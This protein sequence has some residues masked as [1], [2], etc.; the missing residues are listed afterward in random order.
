M[1]TFHTQYLFEIIDKLSP[2]LEAMQKR[3]QKT[4]ESISRSLSSVASKNNNTASAFV[5]NNSKIKDTFSNTSASVSNSSGKMST[6]LALATNRVVA[7]RMA[8]KV[9]TD[10]TRR[11]L[12]NTTSTIN[13]GKSFVLVEAKAKALRHELIKLQ[14]VRS[15]DSY[16]RIGNGG[17]RD[18]RSSGDSYFRRGSRGS[19]GGR[20]G[21]GMGS[22]VDSDEIERRESI[23]KARSGMHAY[24]NMLFSVVLPGAL[25]FGGMLNLERKRFEAKM[26]FSA[27]MDKPN[28][29][30]SMGVADEDK[31]SFAALPYAQK[32]SKFKVK[33][34]ELMNEV[35]QWGMA[36]GTSISAM[37]DG[38]VKVFS[39]STAS[40]EETKNMSKQF[41]LYA[42]SMGMNG[43]DTNNFFRAVGQVFGKGKLT[44]EE[45]NRQFADVAPEMK[46]IIID[47]AIKHSKGKITS[48]NFD[49]MMK[50]GLI[51]P[52][53]MIKVAE[54]IKERM[55]AKLV[56]LKKH[57]FFHA[58]TFT[59]ASVVAGGA[60]GKIMAKQYKL[61][62][63]F[64]GLTKAMKSFGEFLK[65]APSWF[66]TV[67]KYIGVA[68][69]GFMGLVIIGFFRSMFRLF[70]AHM[71]GAS[72][73]KRIIASFGT[74][75]KVVAAAVISNPIIAT[76]SLF[77][78]AV[79]SSV[80]GLKKM[81]QYLDSLSDRIDKAGQLTKETALMIGG[82][83]KQASG[84]LKTQINPLNQFSEKYNLQP[85]LDPVI[86]IL[87]TGIGVVDSFS[88]KG[89]DS[90][91]NV[92]INNGT[93]NY[94]DVE[95]SENIKTSF[96]S[97]FNGSYNLA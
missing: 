84:Y 34:S 5:K 77:T 54:E 68:F 97:S 76:M 20:G 18:Y 66:G 57:W 44:G 56:E 22:Y 75:F 33:G 92:N 1:T 8:A 43:S 6:S 37:Q 90:N 71:I 53:I 25:G 80:I 14:A 31:A 86:N 13:L 19:R 45:L 69:V 58:R 16:F 32:F 29:Y 24:R 83:V 55:E 30:K 95:S 39:A 81:S 3:V 61:K 15:G 88:P 10:W 2:A 78:V 12:E 85:L 60:L 72:L 87:K 48:T 50:L 21:R 52:N 93:S 27:I 51:G 9:K 35:E 38:V 46:K 42:T 26:R 17:G 4:N 74:A 89:K 7:F 23:S 64:E 63:T 73:F 47:T 49:A 28:Y 67:V 41:A 82:G 79:A 91:I 11:M 65:D 94:V 70:A 96:I 62:D 40:F 59:Q 36:Y